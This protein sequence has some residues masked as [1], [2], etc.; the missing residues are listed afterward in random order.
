MIDRTTK[1]RWRRRFRHSRRQ[2]ENMSEQAEEQLEQHVV[3]RLSRLWFVRR[4]LLTWV[5]LLG[6]LIGMLVVQTRSL[7]QYYQSLQPVPGGT[8][9]EGILGTFTNA[10]PLYATGPVDS[11]VSKLVFAGLFKYNNQNVLAGDLANDYEINDRGNVYTVHLKTGITW[12]DGEPLTAED[13]VF[14]YATIQNPDAKSPLASSWQG[15]QVAAVD[16]KTVTFTLPQALSSFPYAMTNGIVPKHL[17]SGIPPTQLRSIAF[18]TTAPVGAGPFKWK[19]VEVS[20]GTPETREER[21]G[22][23]KFDNYIGGA[24]KL[25]GFVIRAFHS[26]SNLMNSFEKRELDGLVGLDE[27]PEKWKKQHTLAHENGFPLTSEAMV[28]FKTSSDVLSDAAVRKAL[29]QA[30]DTAQIRKG[31]GYAVQA[32]NEPFLRTQ[33][34]HDAALAQL[35]YNVDAANLLLDQAGWVKQANGIRA[36]A[37]K[38]LSFQVVTEN[39][40]E[41]TYVANQLRK[42]WKAVG[43]DANFTR[44]ETSD[45]QTTLAFHN[46]DA[47]LYGISIGVDP[48]VFAYWHSSQADIRSANRLNFSEYKSSVADKALEAGRTRTEP[49]LRAIKYRPFLEAWRNDAPAVALYQPR[50]L[51][52]TAESVAGLHEHPINTG[53]DRYANVENWMIHQA[54]VDIN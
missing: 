34:G 14:T 24:P 2:V 28:F 20:G 11:S 38:P 15:V 36:K 43:A 42:Q 30:T 3:R 31:L 1:L 6:L 26:K 9:T 29:V 39:T 37:G 44:Q 51:Y 4:F 54:Y 52:V 41:Y 45:I 46:Y 16:A 32:A 35:P 22:L 53:T 49:A 23:A 33:V 13:V 19:T 21:V 18:N 25:N 27:M 40:P 8:Y 7:S 5:L 50:F 48:D 17:L 10:N 47:L 12:H